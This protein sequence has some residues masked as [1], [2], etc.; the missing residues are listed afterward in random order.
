MVC[1]LPQVS[2]L[3][4]KYIDLFILIKILKKAT[5]NHML[6]LEYWDMWRLSILN[7]E[8]LIKFLLWLVWQV[9]MIRKYFFSYGQ[10]LQQKLIDALHPFLKG[11]VCPISG[12]IVASISSSTLGCFILRASFHI[13]SFGSILIT[14]IKEET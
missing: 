11:R 5:K 13:S 12:A 7:C 8:K 10:A 4:W 3:I 2:K 14:C 6:L 9:K 1:F